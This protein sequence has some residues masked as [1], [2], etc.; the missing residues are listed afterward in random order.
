[1][2]EESSILNLQFNKP[3][4]HAKNLY[5]RFIVIDYIHF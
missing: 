5:N 4:N 1:M 2:Y 3:I